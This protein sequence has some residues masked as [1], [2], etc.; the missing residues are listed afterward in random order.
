MT[1]KPKLVLDDPW[2][3]SHQPAIERRMRQFSETLAEIE[4][5]SKSLATYAT[6]HKYVGIHFHPAA[7]TWTIREWAPAAQAVSLIGDFNNWNR[8]ANP[9][10]P[11]DGGV[12][13]LELPG[14]ALAH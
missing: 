3:E 6:G 1:E 13:K 8:E 11:S 2:L 12:W 9:L 14:D 7:N 5:S 4:K 10:T